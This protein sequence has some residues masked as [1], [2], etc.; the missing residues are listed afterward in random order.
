[1]F[2]IFLHRTADQFAVPVFVPLSESLFRLGFLADDVVATTQNQRGD[3]DQA[4]EH[5]DDIQGLSLGSGF[6]LIPRVASELDCH[7]D[8]LTEPLSGNRTEIPMSHFEQFHRLISE[9]ER[10]PPGVVPVAMMEE[11]VRIAD[12]HLELKDQFLARSCLISA[13]FAGGKPLPLFVALT[14]CLSKLDDRSLELDR[15]E[16]LTLLWQC[17]H[18]IAYSPSFTSISY[19]RFQEMLDDVLRRYQVAGVSPRAVYMLAANGELFMGHLDRAR[20]LHAQGKQCRRDELA[21]TYVWEVF[22]EVDLLMA[23]EQED[24]ALVL[25]EPMLADPTL[26]DDV[27]PWFVNRA[28]FLLLKKGRE[29]EAMAHQ[30]RVIAKIARNPKFIANVGSQLSFL[31]LVGKE[32]RAV[33]LMERHL[34]LAW[35]A[36]DQASRLFFGLH[37]WFLMQF[38]ANRGQ[39][40]I[41][42]R[43]PTLGHPELAIELPKQHNDRF[44]TQE[45]ADWFLTYYR[46]FA[47]EF[48]ERNGNQH[49]EQYI[50]KV[51]GRLN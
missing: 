24:E 28:M 14:W 23:D 47:D 42:I 27:D 12:V 39:D 3:C 51:Q 21:E 46:R 15:Y 33:N 10:L 22:F 16:L 26:A 7:H 43:L 29:Q 34:E 8:S 49:I 11:A 35:T 5:H 30:R 17:K 41:G 31:A 44:S 50:Q 38:L 4:R 32:N 18:A 9:F 36:S 48:N 13:C 19:Q 25:L 1:M 45:L 6:V 37:S 40:T 20:E 2:L